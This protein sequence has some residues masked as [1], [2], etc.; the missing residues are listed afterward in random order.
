[1]TITSE[2]SFGATSE[3]VLPA[4]NLKVHDGAKD[5][6]R[7][8]KR[9]GGAS[10]G[11]AGLGLLILPFG[12]GSTSEILSKLMVALVLGFVGAAI[13]QSGSPVP[14]PELEIDI[15]HKEARLVAYT[16]GKRSVLKRRRFSDLGRAEFAGETVQLWEK[17]DNMLAVV[18]INDE[19]ALRAL[20]R[21]MTDEGLVFEEAA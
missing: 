20:R 4:V 17:D 8:L 18:S 2:Q 19:M 6:V 3:R 14:S 1:M 15:E 11:F 13:Y 7:F 10:I 5:A 12:S 16:E 21:A 9:F